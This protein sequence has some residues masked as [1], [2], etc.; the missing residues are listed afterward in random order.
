MEKDMK[1]VNSQVTGNYIKKL[2]ILKASLELNNL[3]KTEAN[4]EFLEVGIDCVAYVIGVY[5]Q[6]TGKELPSKEELVEFLAA[7]KGDNFT[8]LLS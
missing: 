4:G 8:L 2:E 1:V 6:E 5:K 3:K 7:R